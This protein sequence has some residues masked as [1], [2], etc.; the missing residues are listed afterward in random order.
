MSDCRRHCPCKGARNTRRPGGWN[1]HSLGIWPRHPPEE[2]RSYKTL[3]WLTASQHMSTKKHVHRFSWIHWPRTRIHERWSSPPPWPPRLMKTTKKSRGRAEV[4]RLRVCCIESPRR[5]ESTSRCS[6]QQ[7]ER[8]WG[9]GIAIAWELAL[10][11]PVNLKTQLTLFLC[12]SCS[13][14]RDW[15]KEPAIC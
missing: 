14:R 10:W 4:R 12:C 8:W 7:A 3:I 11:K 15:E 2:Q 1:L 13:G 6:R 5:T 9:K